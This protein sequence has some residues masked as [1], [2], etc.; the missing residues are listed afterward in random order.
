VWEL[1]EIL[2]MV[3]QERKQQLTQEYRKHDQDTGSIEVQ[4]ALLTERINQLNRHFAQAS[5]DYASRVG[6]MRLVGQRRRF[7]RYLERK[8]KKAYHNLVE[9]LGLR[10]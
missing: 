6:L 9:R 10:G 8:N 1:E 2:S 4:V 3:N 5:H 7:L